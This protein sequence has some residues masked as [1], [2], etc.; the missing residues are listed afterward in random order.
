MLKTLP[1]VP[2]EFETAMESIRNVVPAHMIEYTPMKEVVEKAVARAKSSN[3]DKI[4]SVEGAF[5]SAVN[6]VKSKFPMA[7]EAIVAEVDAIVDA[8]LVGPLRAQY[9]S[10]L[11][12]PAKVSLSE[13]NTKRLKQAVNT[14]TGNLWKIQLPMNEIDIAREQMEAFKAETPRPGQDKLMEASFKSVQEGVNIKNREEITRVTKEAVAKWQTMWTRYIVAKSGDDAAF[15]VPAFPDFPGTHDLTA[16]PS[17]HRHAHCKRLP[18][19]VASSKD[20]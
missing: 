19:G 15:T 13:S 20:E 11:A 9:G 3:A 16:H 5:E 6:A 8:V 2:A 12:D 1:L 18:A 17:R 7:D 4:K 14:L 10:K